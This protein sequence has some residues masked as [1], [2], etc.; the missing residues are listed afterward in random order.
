MSLSTTEVKESYD[1][2]TFLCE[3]GLSYG[4]LKDTVRTEHQ[5]MI[6]GNCSAFLFL[7]YHVTYQKSVTES[8]HTTYPNSANVVFT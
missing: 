7:F 6:S 4:Q 1:L 5:N 8:G 3:F 2:N